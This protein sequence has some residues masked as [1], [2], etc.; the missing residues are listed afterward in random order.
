MKDRSHIKDRIAA[1][2]DRIKR[3]TFTAELGNV[4]SMKIV[5]EARRELA[6]LVKTDKK[7]AKNG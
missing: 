7:E 6:D 4:E 5:D 2:E 1:A 3:Y